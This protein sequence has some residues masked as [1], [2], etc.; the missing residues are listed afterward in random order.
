MISVIGFQVIGA[1]LAA[2]VLQLNQ[3]AGL[4]GWQW[5]FLLEGVPTALLGIMLPVLLP[6]S[7]V[8][9]RWLSRANAEL[10]QR[11]V[12][13]SRLKD[14]GLSVVDQLKL[15]FSQKSIYVLSAVKFTKDLTFYGIM[16]WA[17]ALIKN[18]LHG[19]RTGQNSC[20]AW[21]HRSEGDK[22]TGYMEVL[23]TGVPYTVAVAMS[24][25]FAWHSQVCISNKATLD[26]VSHALAARCHCQH[27]LLCSTKLIGPGPSFVLLFRVRHTYIAF[28]CW[29]F[30]SEAFFCMSIR[31]PSVR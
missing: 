17:P 20:K 25:V 28:C 10:V 8:A 7:L 1:P 6:A 2:G 16:F 13:A 29:G 9:A 4:A 14:T 23:L 27:A 22:S 26:G 12:D 19:H 30:I 31:C 24:M 21:E 15:A 3:R 18:F 11:E 5:L